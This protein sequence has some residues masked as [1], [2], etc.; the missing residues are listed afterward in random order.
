[1]E[2]RDHLYDFPCH[3][4]NQAKGY[5]RQI[6]GNRRKSMSEHTR[7]EFLWKTIPGVAL[8][9]VGLTALQPLALLEAEAQ[10]PVT[11]ARDP[12]SYVGTRYGVELDGQFAGWIEFAQGGAATAPVGLGKAGPDNIQRKH[13]AGVK[14][15]DSVV[16]C[17]T[18]MSKSFYEWIKATLDRKFV[19]KN[20]A[21]I[22][23]D[24]NFKPRSRLEWANGL[25][26]E[27]GFPACDAASRNL[28]KMNIKITPAFTRMAGPTLEKPTE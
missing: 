23:F 5:S 1:R 6:V 22:A 14:Y 8:G 13:L 25:I 24:Y 9:G 21:I 12:R 19:R 10:Q 11:T 4:R 20:G 15:E 17:G 7:R 16:S 26:T 3:S 27:V 18:G 2:P 28:A